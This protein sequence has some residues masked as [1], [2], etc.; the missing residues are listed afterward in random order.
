MLGSEGETECF[1]FAA[2][3][4]SSTDSDEHKATV[5]GCVLCEGGTVDHSGNV[6]GKNEKFLE[7][8]LPPV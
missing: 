8:S 1:L 7:I 6:F 3:F 5:K 4:C 2:S